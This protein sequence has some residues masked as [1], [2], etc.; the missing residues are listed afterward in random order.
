MGS[1]AHEY[2]LYDAPFTRLVE[3]LCGCVQRR[4]I[5]L[6]T[7]AGAGDDG[8]GPVDGPT[9]ARMRE[10]IRMQERELDTLRE[11]VRVLKQL[12]GAE[13]ALEAGSD[14]ARHAQ[15]S[16]A[17]VEQLT[18]LVAEKDAA[19]A[20]EAARAEAGAAKVAELQAKVGRH[21]GLAARWGWLTPGH[22]GAS[23]VMMPAAR[24]SNEHLPHSEVRLCCSR[25]AGNDRRCLPRCYQHRR[26][27]PLTRTH[28]T[29]SWKRRHRHPMLASKR[30]KLRTLA[31]R[32]RLP[33]PLNDCARQRRREMVPWSGHRLLKNARS[34]RRRQRRMRV[35][36]RRRQAP[37]G[38]TLHQHRRASPRTVR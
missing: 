7:G 35:P 26:F 22:D 19:I 30:S 10:L 32:H 1:R 23:Y 20:A 16:Q 2:P 27:H 3:A 29:F 11:Q 5:A 28:C 38:K 31:S 6:Y 14:A 17:E 18:Q 4:I 15:A 33:T 21:G 25:P 13:G 9:A 8:E 37:R 34:M 36:A 12:E 24:C